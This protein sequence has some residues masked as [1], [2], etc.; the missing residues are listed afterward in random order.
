VIRL[1]LRSGTAPPLRL[2]DLP[3]LD[4]H[5]SAENSPVHDFAENNDSILLVV[6]PAPSCRDV[7]ASQALKLAQN[8]DPDGKSN[9]PHFACSGWVKQSFS[10]VIGI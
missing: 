6:I 9:L 3:G 2:I 1:A 5:S 4:S 10:Y 8:L 7:S